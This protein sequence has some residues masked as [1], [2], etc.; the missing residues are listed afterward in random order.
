MFKCL[1][2]AKAANKIIG[3]LKRTF[4]YKSEEINMQL[5]KSLLRPKLE[6]CIEAWCPRLRKTLIY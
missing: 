4:M 6:Y 1:N 2:A 5:Y 3:M